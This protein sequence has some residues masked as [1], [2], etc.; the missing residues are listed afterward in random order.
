MFKQL[1]PLTLLPLLILSTVNIQTF[2]QQGVVDSTMD[3]AVDTTILLATSQQPILDMA[4][5]ISTI[6]TVIGAVG[7]AVT[8]AIIGTAFVRNC[9]QS[10]GTVSFG[11]F[12]QSKFTMFIGAL[13]G[14]FLIT[15]SVGVL[16]LAVSKGI[17]NVARSIGAPAK[18]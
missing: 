2:A 14:I 11:K 16:P 7:I 4:L 10:Q 12:A 13:F 15:L 18:K 9:F 6:I 17:S 8:I 3:T 1:K 5:R